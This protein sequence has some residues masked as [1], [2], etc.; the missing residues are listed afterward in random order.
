MD[1]QTDSKKI[2]IFSPFYHPH[3][4][5]LQSH[6]REFNKYVSMLGYDITVFTPQL[7]FDSKREEVVCDNACPPCVKVIRFPAFELIPNFPVPKFWQPVFWRQVFTLRLEKRSIIISRTRFFLTS[8]LALWFAK[9]NRGKWMHVEHGSD[10]PKLE[11]MWKNFI[12]FLYDKTLGKLVLRSADIVVANSRASADF[13]KEISGRECK[14]IYR[15]VD[16]EKILTTVPAGV[17]LPAGSLLVVFVGRLI[18][19]KGVADLLNALKIVDCKELFCF[20]IGGGPQEKEL[21]DI[22]NNL[23]LQRVTF[24]GEKGHQD[25]LAL[26]KRADIVINPSY[27]EG[28]PTSIIEAALCHKAIIATNVGGTK[29]IID[30]GV[31]GLMHKPMDVSA[32]ATLL[33]ELINNPTERERLGENAFRQNKDLFDWEKASLQYVQLFKTME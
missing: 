22:A 24:L 29:E 6:A 32:L 27:T 30:H 12:A 20:I 3:V 21:K 14:F 25:A 13:V 4:G 26:I 10:F 1:K 28:L 9:T 7:P 19:G 17:E 33:R 23:G 2:L 15:G 11:S 8:L 31:S 5:G 16:K 18:S